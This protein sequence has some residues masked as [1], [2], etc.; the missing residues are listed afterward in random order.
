MFSS[1]SAWLAVSGVWLEFVACLVVTA[2]P[3]SA[4]DI[5]RDTRLTWL[6][7]LDSYF[8]NSDSTCGQRQFEKFDT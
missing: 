7:L 5:F 1:P 3:A 8:S 2:S 4:V 6:F